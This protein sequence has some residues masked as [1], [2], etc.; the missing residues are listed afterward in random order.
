[1]EW[2]DRHR[3]QLLAGFI[4]LVVIFRMVHVRE[5]PLTLAAFAPRDAR[6]GAL[7]AEVTAPALTLLSAR[8]I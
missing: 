5:W 1:M 6:D 4:A 2:L 8:L 7:R 3:W